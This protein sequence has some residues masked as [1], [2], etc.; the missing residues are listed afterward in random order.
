[1]DA[2]ERA[3]TMCYIART[4]KPEVNHPHIG[5]VVCAAVDEPKSVAWVSKDVAKWIRD[6]LAIERVPTWWVRLHLGTTERYH[7]GDVSP[8][9]RV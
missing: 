1:M 5:T 3:N 2:T 9:E 7:E 4:T 6:G 8:A